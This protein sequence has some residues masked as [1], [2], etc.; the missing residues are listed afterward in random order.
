MGMGMCVNAILL[1]RRRLDVNVDFFATAGSTV[2]SNYRLSL[3]SFAVFGLV[4]VFY[5]DLNIIIKIG[6]DPAQRAG[7]GGMVRL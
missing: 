4:F 3:D 7:E 2:L 5:F 6:I 1:R